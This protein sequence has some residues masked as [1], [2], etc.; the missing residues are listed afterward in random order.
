MTRFTNGMVSFFERWMPDVFIV[1]IAL[2]VVTFVL[3]VTNAGA[4]PL[5]A[6]TA[7][8][9]GFWNILAFTN[10][11]AL[12]LLFGHALAHTPI[13]Q[14]LLR[15]VAGTVRSPRGAYLTVTF[16][17]CAASLFSWALGLVAGA[18]LARTVGAVTRERGI[19]VHYPL[20]VACAYAGIVIWHQGLSA[21]IGLV[22]ATPG[23]FLEDKIG[24]IPTSE[25]LFTLWNMGV[26]FF[27][28]L[29]LP[30]VMAWIRPPDDACRAQSASASIGEGVSAGKAVS[31]HEAVPATRME[32]SRLLNILIVA[33]G[34]TY[35][36]IQFVV[37]GEGLQLNLLNFSF[38]ILG[39]ALSPS[40]MHY[41]RLVTDAVK[42]VGPILLQYPFYAGIAGMMADTG[43]ARIVVE[44][45]CS[46]LH[47]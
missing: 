27:V 5:A 9:D 22:V 30:F 31:D 23:H 41:A 44:F 17:S 16:V 33:G 12:V 2:S 20:L 15:M 36:F 19:R 10:Q 11:M 25:T 3:A 29:T 6:V 26:A 35:L 46:S 37:R 14:R 40:P 45:F 4:A 34:A 18:V 8:G 21:S 1:A 7:W 42:V 43:L 24:I 32:E 13:M 28:L 39:I 47:C 38:L